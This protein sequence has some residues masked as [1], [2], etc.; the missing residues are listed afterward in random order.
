MRISRGRPLFRL[1]F[2]PVLAALLALAP[3]GAQGAASAA[4]GEEAAPA[5]KHAEQEKVI[6]GVY[7]K[8]LPGIEVKSNT[9]LADFYIWFRWQGPVDPT[10]SWEFVNIVEPN[11]ISKV[12]VYTDEEKGDAKPDKLEDGSS[13]QVF[14][15]QGKFTHPFDLKHYPFDEQ[16]VTIELED[17]KHS[18]AELVY[19]IE[20]D[21]TAYEPHISIPG[22]ELRAATPS[23]SEST[24]RTNFG[25]PRV[26]AGEEK[27][28]RF[29]FS[30]H[31][32]RPIIGYLVKTVLPVAIIMLITFLTFLIGS[33]YFEA[34]LGLAITSLI[35][36]VALQ[37]TAVS[38]LPSV[39]Y[40]VL[41]DK[42]YNLS[43]AVIFFTLVES[44]IAVRLHDAGRDQA[45]RTLDKVALAAGSVLCFGGM[46]LI[47]GLR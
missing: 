41:L 26:K 1:G 46:A 31:L 37:L 4:A 47:I 12:A 25:D 16:D 6:V 43:Y 15:V 44:V 29:T 23:I 9:Y 8:E 24:Y 2:L 27:Y 35:S 22:W 34:R 18:L 21:Q 33:A 32:G 5:E 40:M 13:Y 20:A 45:A 17:S 3:R 14:H 30:V 42:I 10:K 39:G 11:N 38:D 36:A 28:S 7:L 19:Q